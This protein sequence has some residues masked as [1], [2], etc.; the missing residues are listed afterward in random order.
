MLV[1][2]QGVANSDGLGDLVRSYLDAGKPVLNMQSSWVTTDGGVNVVSAMPMAMGMA[3]GGYPGNYFAPAAGVSVGAGRTAQQVLDSVDILGPLLNLLP[4]LKKT[5]LVQDFKADPS[6]LKVI[7]TLHNALATQQAQG[8]DVFKESDTRLYRYLVLW[9]DVVRRGV[10]YGGSLASTGT[11]A[12][13]AATFLRTYASDSWLAF[14]RSSTTAPPQGSGIFML[15]AA[16]KMAVGA[17]FET[18]EVTIPQAS[19][20]T[21]IGRAAVPA[22]GVVV[23]VKDSAGAVSLGL[24]TNHLRAWGDAVADKVYAHPH[25]PQSFRI[26]LPKTGDTYFVTPFGG[27]LMLDHPGLYADIVANRTTGAGRRLDLAT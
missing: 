18:I 14:N 22:K 21:L 4:T 26:P 6:L 12:G 23:Q 10:V 9:A 11:A 3:L 19:G 24:Q 1:F 16:A 8:I 7:D 27:P 13:N 2:G 17:S 25:R 15:A 5:D 20:I